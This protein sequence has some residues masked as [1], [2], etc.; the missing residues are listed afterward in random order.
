M[1]GAVWADIAT[2]SKST[3]AAAR[4]ASDFSPFDRF[5]I[6]RTHPPCCFLHRQQT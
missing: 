2:G 1:N 4:L 3:P 5:L 6:F